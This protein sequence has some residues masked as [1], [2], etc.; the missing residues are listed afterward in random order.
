MGIRENIEQSLP[1]IKAELIW[2]VLILLLVALGR[3][4][5][6]VAYDRGYRDGVIAEKIGLLEDHDMA[7]E[8]KDGP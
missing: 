2:V 7:R 5:I 8:A 6:E 1:P 4:G 3:Y